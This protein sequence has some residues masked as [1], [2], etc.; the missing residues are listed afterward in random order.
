MRSR[1][2]GVDVTS[3]DAVV[4]TKVAIQPAVLALLVALPIRMDERRIG[5]QRSL[6]IQDRGQG[7]VVDLYD[8]G[9]CLR[10]RERLRRDRHDGLA[11]V[12]HVVARIE[13]LVLDAEI[14]IFFGNGCVIAD[15]RHTGHRLRLGGRDATQARHRMWR[16]HEDRRE[17][18]FEGH[19]GGVRGLA[20]HFGSSIPADVSLADHGAVVGHMFRH[21]SAS[22]SGDLI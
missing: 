14:E 18:T 9:R 7:F 20:R 12:A 15:R 2:S 3:A 19:V 6:C 16:A 11:R 10:L 1:E 4:T 5:S 13:P 17:R 8:C 21:G 22:R